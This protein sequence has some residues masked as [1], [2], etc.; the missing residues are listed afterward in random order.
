M[1]T[2]FVPESACLHQ[3]AL[4]IGWNG[5]G[6]IGAVLRV[7]ERQHSYLLNARDLMFNFVLG[8]KIE[9]SFLGKMASSFL[10]KVVSTPCKNYQV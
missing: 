6:A 1:K 5:E 3:Q 8:L 4:R 9:L 7:I 2:F 10:V